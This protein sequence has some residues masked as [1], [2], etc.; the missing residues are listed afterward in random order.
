MVPVIY[1]CL[2]IA[3]RNCKYREN[4]AKGR[5]GADGGEFQWPGFGTHNS[6]YR[7][8]Q[9]KI[10]GEAYFWKP[11]LHVDKNIPFVVTIDRR[12]RWEA[13]EHFNIN[14]MPDENLYMP[15]YLQEA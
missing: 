11:M 13:W 8:E 2:H 12:Q 3:R 9:V 1:G 14:A 7:S 6:V 4:C 10:T 5:H 15:P